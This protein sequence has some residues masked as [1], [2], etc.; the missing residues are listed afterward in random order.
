MEWLLVPIA[1]CLGAIYWMRGS[2]EAECSK[3]AREDIASAMLRIAQ[4]QLE[5][6]TLKDER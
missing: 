5:L 2:H 6:K 3:S 1:V 4:A